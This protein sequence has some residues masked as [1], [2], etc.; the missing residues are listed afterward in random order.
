MSEAAHPLPEPEDFCAAVA[1]AMTGRKWSWLADETG[2]NVGTLKYQL[3]IN[4]DA[5][6]LRTGK[7]VA[8]ALN[9]TVWGE[10]A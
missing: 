7:R 1:V 6:K 9:L 8:T 10:A 5:L 2:I 4:P 3:I